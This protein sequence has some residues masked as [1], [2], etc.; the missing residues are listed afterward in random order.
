MR[1]LGIRTSQRGLREGKEQGHSAP[2]SS[3]WTKGTQT[4]GY[5][6]S[7]RGKQW[8]ETLLAVGTATGPLLWGYQSDGRGWSEPSNGVGDDKVREKNGV[9]GYQ[10]MWDSPPYAVN[11]TG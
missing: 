10:V 11:V 2:L 6:V 9:L 3:A 1:P 8:E 7:S 5:R 4:T